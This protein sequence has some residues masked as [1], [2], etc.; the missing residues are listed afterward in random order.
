MYPN[1]IFFRFFNVAISL[2]ISIYSN[3]KCITCG[4]CD[5]SSTDVSILPS[6]CSNQLLI[7]L[8]NPMR[9][10]DNQTT[11]L[12][13]ETTWRHQTTPTTTKPRRCMKIHGT[14][15]HNRMADLVCPGTP[16]TIRGVV[17]PTMA[18]KPIA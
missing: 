6:F 11:L 10:S 18:V 4:A 2:A 14:D 9:V 5:F 15:P 16:R 7:A 8:K 3:G 17:P 13:E 12:Y 1:M